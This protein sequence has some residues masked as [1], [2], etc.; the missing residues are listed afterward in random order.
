MYHSC[1]I[2]PSEYFTFTYFASLLSCFYNFPISF[3]VHCFHVSSCFSRSQSF[4]S[5]QSPLHMFHFYTVGY[6]P[7]SPASLHARRSWTDLGHK[8]QNQQE[9]S[10]CSV[11]HR[12]LRGSVAH[13]RERHSLKYRGQQCNHFVITH[14]SPHMVIIIHIAGQVQRRAGSIYLT[15]ISPCSPA[16]GQSWEL[17]AI[18]G[19]KIINPTKSGHK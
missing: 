11:Q 15:D 10:Q 4:E 17:R 9:Q 18:R 12:Q 7:C 3:A 19:N 16:T 5:F 1:F 14:S 13:L 6:S 8:Q 2:P